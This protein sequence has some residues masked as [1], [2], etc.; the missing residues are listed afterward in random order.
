MNSHP[1]HRPGSPR[2]LGALLL[3]VGIVLT[4]GVPS[5]GAL[6][7]TKPHK[8]HGPVDVLYAGSLVGMME[9]GIGPAFDA[10]TGYT[11]N[12]FSAGSTALASAIKGQTQVGDVFVS[13]SPK[14]DESLQGSSNG[15]WVSWYAAFATSPLVIGYNPKSPFAAQ[16]MS[17]PWYQVVTQ[18]GF[19]LGRTDPATD[20]KGALAVQALTM[21]ASQFSDPALS[22]ISTQTSGIYAEQSLVGLLQAGQLDAGFFYA[23]EASAAGIPTV[24][25]SGIDLSAQYTVT[26]LNRAPDSKAALAF[27]KFL[28]SPLGQ[29][30]LKHDG[31]S[32]ATRPQVIGTPPKTLKATLHVR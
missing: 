32:V 21:A 29:S 14:A 2:R 23:A 4:V 10:E 8:N 17:K 3:G 31:L 13:A 28:L 20:P 22:A 6:G 15:N 1:G 11:F 27:V 12:G 18:P 16:L 25:L 26:V 7:A 24:P 30:I 9:Q 19:I 5:T